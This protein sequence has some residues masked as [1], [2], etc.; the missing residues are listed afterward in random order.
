MNGVLKGVRIMTQNL[1]SESNKKTLLL[2]NAA[3][4]RGLIEGGLGYAAAYPG[5][6]STEVIEY[7]MYYQQQGHPIQVE[8]SSNEVVA[9]ESV[10]AGSLAGVRSFY[11]SKHVGWNVAA[12]ALM[13]LSYVGV[14]A[15]LIVLTADD[16][17]MHSSQNEQDNRWYARMARIPMIEPHHP[18]E[19]QNMSREAFEWSERFGLPFAI[20]TTTRLAH[21]RGVIELQEP[22]EPVKKPPIHHDPF[23]YVNVPAVARKNHV[24]LLKD[25]AKVEHWANKFPYN[26]IENAGESSIGIVTSGMPYNYVKESLKTLNKENLPIFRLGMTY[27][28]PKE[29]LSTFLESLD[30]VLVIEELD[31]ILETEIRALIQKELPDSNIKVL[32]KEDGL[33]SLNGE[34]LPL[35]VLASLERVLLG[36]R[37]YETT[38]QEARA[39]QQQVVT[40]I[41]SRPPVFCAGCPHRSTYFAAK[42]AFR[43][44]NPI[45]ASDI[46][47]Y[48]LGINP[49]FEEADTL[50]AMGASISMAHGFS[51]TREEGRAI[52]FIGDSTFFHT[53]LPG[54][55]NAVY[56]NTP[57]TVVVLDNLT[58][59]MTGQQ[60]NPGYAPLPDQPLGY[61]PIKIEDVARAMGVKFVEVVDAYDIDTLR[62]T[63]EAAAKV[64]GPAVV[65]SRA[66][67]ELSQ[68][69]RGKPGKATPYEVVT[70]ACIACGRCIEEFNCPAIL[71]DVK[72]FPN[73]EKEQRRPKAMIN[74]MACTGCSACARVCPV[75][76]IVKAEE[77]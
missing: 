29:K 17:G 64:D 72:D 67:C 36:T 26:V 60:E 43:R 7:L 33:S 14:N 75:N 8:W 30:Q 18:K 10:L 57:I 45:Y 51:R 20:R 16:P 40:V 5:T 65:V 69:G 11:A 9:L 24:R 6:P 38:L 12:D 49:P 22:R 19:A 50:I 2:G 63:L 70:D 25:F 71:W 27:P 44:A 4:A 59:A 77:H 54:L 31:P 41:P 1:L 73:A 47:C 61:H 48:S 55:A 53:G 46:G 39:S 15:G 23:R 21:C 28:L 13:M 58:T 66:P 34:L 3:I 68:W 74:P 52:A 35:P 42:R 32:G 37:H 62:K 76:A 56:H